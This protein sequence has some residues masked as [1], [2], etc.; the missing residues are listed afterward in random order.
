MKQTSII[1]IFIYYIYRITTNRRK[2]YLNNY[3]ARE[4]S[5]LVLYLT[6]TI[7]IYALA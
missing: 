2:N 1:Y 4:T 3:H 7:I 6:K 5:I